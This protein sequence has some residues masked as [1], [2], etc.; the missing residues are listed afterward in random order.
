VRL[1]ESTAFEDS[2]REDST[3]PR[4]GRTCYRLLV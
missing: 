1:G 4:Y 3:A 2:S